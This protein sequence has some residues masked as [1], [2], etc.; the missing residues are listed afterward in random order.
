M[1][2]QS[3]TRRSR[4]AIKIIFLVG[5]CTLGLQGCGAAPPPNSHDIC[6]VFEQY[7]NWYWDSINSYNQWGIPVSVQMAII[8]QE[9]DFRSDARPPRTKLLGTIP[10]GRPTTAYGY[11]Q[12]LNE[13]WSDYQQGTKN[14]D[15]SRDNFSDAVDFIGWYSSKASKSLNISK[16]DAYHLY[17]AYHEGMGNYRNGSYR[18]QK[19]LLDVADHVQDTSNR[20]RTQL[21]YCYKKIPKPSS[22]SW[23]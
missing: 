20:Y 21:D 14:K 15:A 8:Q 12:A 18:N 10:W 5:A 19:W 6:T 4:H 7:P 23:F 9:S 13:T 16:R 2:R 1:L 17:L 22:W 3:L 11:A